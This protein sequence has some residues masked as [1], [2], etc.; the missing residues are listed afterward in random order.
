M[1]TRQKSSSS[2]SNDQII[3]AQ[4]KTVADNITIPNA[5]LPAL[6]L[7]PAIL[8]STTNSVFGFFVVAAYNAIIII[9]N[10]MK[11]KLNPTKC[12]ALEYVWN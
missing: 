1:I 12:R 3:F 5:E 7:I 8:S 4:K 11:I 6:S 10:P 2:I 9:N